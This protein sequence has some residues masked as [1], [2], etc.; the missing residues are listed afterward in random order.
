M[1]DA[2]R[3]N[4]WPDA[5]QGATIARSGYDRAAFSGVQKATGSPGAWR[6]ARRPPGHPE[7][8]EDR[9]GG[10][11]DPSLT[12]ILRPIFASLRMTL[13]DARAESE[14]TVIGGISPRQ[15]RASRTRA[16]SLT[17]R[18]HVIRKHSH[19]PAR[20]PRLVGRSLTARAR[21]SGPVATSSH[22][23]SFAPAPRFFARWR[24][25]RGVGPRRRVRQPATSPSRRRGRKLEFTGSTLA[26]NLIA[27]AGS[28]RTAAASSPSTSRCRA[29]LYGHQFRHHGDDVRCD[30]R[31]SR[32]GRAELLR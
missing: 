12:R 2:G 11:S 24:F 22:A 28:K 16:S 32:T 4:C 1:A 23:R 19:A 13:P 29:F 15:T 5:R 31:L 21:S 8:S 27:Q 6:E 26:A 10:A 9:V 7:R 3:A 20:G 18:C 17:E 14:R 25:V 30:V